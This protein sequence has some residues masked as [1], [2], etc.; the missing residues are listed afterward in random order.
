MSVSRREFLKVAGAVGLIAAAGGSL[1]LFTA[2]GTKIKTGQTLK[3]GA[4]TPSTGVAAEKGK[5]GQDGLLDCYNYI[6]TE[7]NG[8]NGYLIEPVWRDSQY[9]PSIVATIVPEFMD[10]G[11]LLFTTHA[12][13]EM[14]A[15][16][17][18]AN[19]AEFPGVSTFTSQTLYHPPKH[20]YGQMPDYG[21][22]WI[23]F[24]KYYLANIW[25]GTSKPKMALHLLNNSTGTGAQYGA[26]A[27]A[28]SLGIQI[29][30]T[31]QHTTTITSAIDSLTRIKAQNP[32]VMFISSTPQ[33][34][35]IILKDAHSLG[36]YPGMTIGCAHASFTKSLIDLAGADVVE[37]VYGVYSTVTWTDNVSGMAKATEYCQKYNN[38]DYGNMDYLSTWSTALVVAEILKQAL[39]NVGYDVLAKGDVNSWRAVEN[40][41]IQKLNGYKVEGITAPVNYTVG[42]QRLSKSLK[43]F[44]INSG[45][46][47][48]IGDWVNA[49]YIKYEDF[50]WFP[51]S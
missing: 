4:M 25:K 24:A 7:R 19:P 46:I 36:M 37:G 40:S 27:M 33:P 10:Q 49:P 9:D 15:A 34:T 42:D 28:D 51:K 35:S 5:P 39:N 11:C 16:M 13:A 6:N 50:S 23:A 38:Q 18:I 30:I 29:V 1:P 2:C 17:A 26:N 48:A 31:E 45:N 8:V 32:D 47:T 41:G 20:I 14:T 12:S 21:D 44:R 43:I 3:V 22:D